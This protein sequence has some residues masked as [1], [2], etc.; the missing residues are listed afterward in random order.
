MVTLQKPEMGD[1]TT[2][3]SLFLEIVETMQKNHLEHPHLA[4][5]LNNLA[6]VYAGLGEHEKELIFEQEAARIR[7][8]RKRL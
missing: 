8:A 4:I 6:L 3:E 7:A 1:L 5:I 2:A